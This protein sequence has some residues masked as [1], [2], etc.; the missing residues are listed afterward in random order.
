MRTLQSLLFVA[1]ILI[2]AASHGQFIGLETPRRTVIA[3][4]HGSGELWARTTNTGLLQSSIPAS[5]GYCSAFGYQNSDITLSGNVLTASFNGGGTCSYDGQPVD[6]D[7]A[8]GFCDMLLYFDLNSP[9]NYS[10]ITSL[11][12]SPENGISLVLGGPPSTNTVFVFGNAGSPFGTGPLSG[13]ISGILEPGLYSLYV[14]AG[15]QSGDCGTCAGCIS[16]TFSG[17]G[18]LEM[19]LTVSSSNIVSTTISGHIT[20]ACSGLPITGA[21]LQIG[22]LTAVSD[23]NGYYSKTNLPPATYTVIASPAN[24][25]SATNTVTTSASATSVTQNF[26]LAPLSGCPVTITGRVCCSCDTNPIAGALV[27]IGPYWTNTDSQGNYSIPNL[28]PNTYTLSVSASDYYQT[29]IPLTITPEYLNASTPLLL[30]PNGQ[31]TG[32]HI[33]I[34]AGTINWL[35][36]N[37][38]KTLMALFTPRPPGLTLKAAACKLGY[39][40]FNWYQRVLVNP[41]VQSPYNLPTPFNDPPQHWADGSNNMLPDPVSGHKIWA[42][43]SLR[44]VLN[45]GDN[46]LDP[47]DRIAPQHTRA[48][49]TV[50]EYDDGPSW[51][52]MQTGQYIQL[53]TTLVGV[54]QGDKYDCLGNFFFWKT[55]SKGGDSTGGITPNLLTEWTD[56]NADGGVFE[57]VTNVPPGDLPSDVYTALVADGATFPVTIQPATLTT[58]SGASVMFAISPT[59]TSSA[60][61]YQWRINGTNILNATNMTL[62]LTSVTTNSTGVYD[63]ILSNTNGSIASAVATLAVVNVPII[64]TPV[65]IT[66]GQVLLIWTAPV[67]KTCQLQ[68]KTNLNQ[69]NWINVGSALTATNTV[70]SATNAIGSDKQRFYRVQQQ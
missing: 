14:T 12:Q 4:T 47:Y 25:V 21:T 35:I 3:E 37:N 56:T 57:L 68:Y 58:V 2:P 50:L 59:N 42:A 67:G 6:Y 70:M 36:I 15:F 60:L 63:A 53:V 54:K 44:Y 62:Q 32:L 7:A 5:D 9:C 33:Q 61:N 66:N 27:T 11:T 16:T 69:T 39:Q 17:S 34:S 46:P 26:S 55:N 20:D 1:A 22:Y 65:M 43:D 10:I 49:G 40:Y 51:R 38:S 31:D 23:I 24:Y 30:V 18:Q 13:N 19:L 29:N 41:P 64:Q 52:G 28:L 45:E 8:E 48:N